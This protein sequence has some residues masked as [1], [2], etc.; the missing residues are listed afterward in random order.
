MDQVE[1]ERKK[2]DQVENELKN[3]LGEKE[4]DE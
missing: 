4:L 2:V 1:S 3:E